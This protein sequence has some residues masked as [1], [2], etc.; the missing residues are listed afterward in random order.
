MASEQVQRLAAAYHLWSESKGGSIDHWLSLMADE[1]DF[2]SL[3]DDMPQIPF[4]RRPQAREGVRQYLEGLTAQWEMLYYRVDRYIEQGEDV[5]VV[6]A[7]SWR[8]RATGKV[9]ETA[10]VNL[11]RFKGGQAVGFF[12]FI[13]TDLIAR[14]CAS[15]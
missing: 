14:C 11:W 5:A 6:G 1:I 3:V 9:A 13:D 4:G 2:R 12:E 7:T 10:L 8:N 15:D